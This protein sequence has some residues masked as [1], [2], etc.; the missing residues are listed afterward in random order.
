MGGKCKFTKAKEKEYPGFVVSE[1]GLTWAHCEKCIKDI[2]IGSGVSSTLERHIK[3]THPLNSVSVSDSSDQAKGPIQPNIIE[4]L[5]KKKYIKDQT[6]FSEVLH[7]C[8]SMLSNTSLRYSDVFSRSRKLYELMFPDST[9]AHNFTCGRTKET[10][11][12]KAVGQFS[13]AK[14]AERINF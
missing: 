2:N 6:M 7:V 9:I 4:A 5:A 10:Y 3:K 11:I 1:K 12:T 8:Q 14:Q 13:K